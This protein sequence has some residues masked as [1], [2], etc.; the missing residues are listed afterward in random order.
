VQ[1]DFAITPVVTKEEDLRPTA[2]VVVQTDRAS[3]K[4]ALLFGTAW[5]ASGANGSAAANHEG[6]GRID[7]VAPGAT[8][9]ALTPEYSR[10]HGVIEGIIWA[11]RNPKIDIACPE[12]ISPLSYALKDG[13]E[14]EA[15]VFDRLSQRYDKPIMQ[16]GGNDPGMGQINGA[17]VPDLVFSI[18]EYQSGE[19]YRKNF[20]IDAL[21]RDNSS[22]GGSYGPPG[23]GGIKPS[24]MTPSGWLTPEPGFARGTSTTLKGVR[25]LQPGYMILGATSQAP[26]T[27]RGSLA[28]LIIAARQLRR[29]VTVAELMAAT[30]RTARFMSLPAY[31]QG[32]GLLQVDAAWK[33][34]VRERGRPLTQIAFDAPVH[35]AT[36]ALLPTPN[37]GEGL[38][39]REGWVAGMHGT[40]NIGIPSGGRAPQAETYRVET[41]GN[42][43]PFATAATVRVPAR[44]R[45]VLSLAIAPKTAGAHS[46]SLALRDPATG[47][48]AGQTL[49]T[50]VAGHPL[51]AAVQYTAT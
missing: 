10:L 44:S 11:I 30:T 12:L 22:F 32:S 40:R 38:F 21:A 9:V 43:G 36:S 5:H 41:R 25:Q 29:P 33:A 28:I 51:V 3:R 48:I 31:V 2:G 16:P 34:L 42:A 4:L 39:E 23:N 47:A 19:S 8:L 13:R 46:A 26:T 7:G 17:G 24:F 45:T 37:Q 14:V 20:G 1:R 27:A 49:L 6:S 15:I 18:E 50:V 35:T